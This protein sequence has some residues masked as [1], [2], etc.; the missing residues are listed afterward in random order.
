MVLPPHGPQDGLALENPIGRFHQVAE[1]LKLPHRQGDGFPGTAHLPGG[2]V[3]NQI[4]VDQAF[5]VVLLLLAVGAAAQV[6]PQPGQQLLHGEGLEHEVVGARIKGFHPLLHPIPAGEHHDRRGDAAGP[7]PAAH[8]HTAEI[9]Q[10][11]V[12]EN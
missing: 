3:E 9:R 7:D 2:G 11:P 8:L 4:G 6:G 12:E 1:Q 10:E 5:V